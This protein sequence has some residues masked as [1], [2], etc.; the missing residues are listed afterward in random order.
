[1]HDLS[2]PHGPEHES[3]SVNACIPEENSSV[4]YHYLEEVIQF[5]AI[6]IGIN[7]M[8]ARLDICHAFRNLGK[9]ALL[10]HLA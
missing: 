2:F 6:E 8:A 5:M 4:Q 3:E 9:L 10:A 7:C 1:M